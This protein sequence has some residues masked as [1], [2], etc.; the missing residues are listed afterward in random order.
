MEAVELLVYSIVSCSLLVSCVVSFHRQMNAFAG[1]KL[2]KEEKGK[3]KVDSSKK[4][5]AI[6]YSAKKEITHLLTGK[7]IDELTQE[8]A[9]TLFPIIIY[10]F[11][12]CIILHIYLFFH[13]TLIYDKIY[14]CY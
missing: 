12:I 13:N 8:I 14:N 3:G 1:K 10:F 4:L 9:Y 11:S 6:N 5:K 2:N 7:I